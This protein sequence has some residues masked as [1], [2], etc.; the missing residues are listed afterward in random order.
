VRDE[1]AFGCDLYRP[2][3][4]HFNRIPAITVLIRKYRDDGSFGVVAKRLI[5]LITNCEFGIHGESS[6]TQAL[7]LIRF[8][9]GF[10]A[11]EKRIRG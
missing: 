8:K 3:S 6:H 2:V 1:T 10:F 7:R 9:C 4:K 5:D 11:I